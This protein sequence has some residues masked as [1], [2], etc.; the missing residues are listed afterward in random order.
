M[1]QSREIN[2]KTKN[3]Y[4]ILCFFMPVTQLEKALAP[5]I[6]EKFYY[7]N[8]PAM[9]CDCPICGASLSVKVFFPKEVAKCGSCGFVG[10]R[11][12]WVRRLYLG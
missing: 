4:F 2:T 1:F 5:F 12:E 8:Y 11:E 7:M 9:C 6:K 10:G 3:H